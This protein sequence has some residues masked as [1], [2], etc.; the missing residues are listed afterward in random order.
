MI[1][2]GVRL[3]DQI[4]IALD[5]GKLVVF[6]GAGV[7]LP[8]PSNLPLFNGLA[9]QICG[10]PSVPPGKEDQV[11][12]KMARNG[13]DVHVA[14]A[15]ILCHPKTHPTELHR[16][17]LRIFGSPDKVRIVTTNFDSHFSAAAVS[18][19][20]KR[21]VKEFYA[22]ALPLGDDFNG[23]VYLH[24]SAR[25]N[26]KA[27]VLTDKNFGAAYLTRG[28]ARDFLISLFSQY[29][30]LFVGY[31]HNDITTTYL[32]L[33]LNRAQVKPRWALVSSDLKPEAEERWAHLEIGVQQYPTDLS[34]KSNSHYALTD[35]FLGWAKHNRESLL[36]RSRR[37]KGIASSL[38]PESDTVSEYLA[39]CLRHPQLAQDFCNAIR[40]PA[41]IG[42]MNAKRYF[43][44]FFTQ[45]NEELQPHQ[46][47][48]A[49][50]LSTFVR[51]RH[52][53][54]LLELIRENDQR[55]SKS[56]SQ[57]FGHIVWAE[58]TK[59]PDPNFS[60][61]VSVLL[62][63]GEQALSQDMWA[64]LLQT[65]RIPKDT[66]VALRLF[67]LLTTPQIHL[68]TYIDFT[69][70]IAGS[71]ENKPSRMSKKKV[72]Y[73]IEWPEGSRHWL[74]EAWEK[75][76]K[77]N[78]ALL[79][80]PL[81]L[82]ATKQITLAHILLRG[83]GKAGE[84]VDFLSWH[85]SSIAE[86]GQNR[87]ALHECLSVLVDLLRDVLLYWHQTDPARARTQVEAWWAS[88]LPLLQ[89]LAVFGL[90]VDPKLNGDECLEW[91]LANDLVFRL[92]MKKEVFD[93]LA[94]AYPSS[95]ESTRKKLVK[96]IQQ[97][98][99][100]KLR[101]RLGPDTGAYEQFNILTWLQRSDAKCSL[102][103]G[104]I[105]EIKKAYPN[106]EE[107]EH[108][109]FDHWS[110]EVRT[111]DP[112]EG[113]DVEKILSQPPS[114]FV[115]SLLLATESSFR[116]DCWDHLSLL[117]TLFG[118]NRAWGKEFTEELS[119]RDGA[120][121]E[122]WN[123]VFSAWKQVAKAKEDWVWIL[124]VVDGLPELPEIF[125]G[126]ANLISDIWRAEAEIKS[127]DA[128]VGRAAVLMGRAWEICSKVDEPPDDSYREWLT[129]AINH[130]GGWIGEFWVHYCSHLR[131]RAGKEWKGIPLDLKFRMK[132]AIHGAS[133]IK[134]YARIAITPW[135]SYI[136]VWDKK[137]A[138]EHFLPLLDWQRNS[139]VAQQT[140]SVLLNYRRAAF[141]EMEAQLL[142]YY[143]QVC[144][145]VAA[146]LKQTPE[147]AD[148]F[149][150]HTLQNLGHYLAGLAMR[151]IKNPLESGFFRDFLPRL[152]EKVCGSLAQG[153]G[154]F[155][156][157]AP[158][159]VGGVWNDWLEEY[160]DSRL[161]GVP[162]ALSDQETTAMA[163]WG[164][165][166]APIFPK[167][168]E[169]ITQMRLKGIFSYGI[170]DNLAN[171]TLLEQFPKDS[172]RYVNALMKGEDHPHLHKQLVE[173]H[174][175]FRLSIPSELE[176]KEFE[177]LLYLRGWK[178]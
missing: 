124:G 102:V 60:T 21:V 151:V 39:Y 171:S 19:F 157:A 7:S 9:C 51:R 33:G 173:M 28:W 123:G 49:H 146:M 34:N 48:V 139:V 110:G 154:D 134:V 47:V 26:P 116:R 95:S 153:M 158:D 46:R 71:G 165:Y 35:F 72:D 31:S 131:Q 115:D 100:G 59:S 54:L 41:W 141:L 140:W 17:A 170:F 159:K 178:K 125:A 58:E 38:P 111:V 121:K 169:R 29:T 161:I 62:S 137:F 160:L 167:I 168:V 5:E 25:E 74:H 93:V 101:R 86:H 13:T 87:H 83:A 145:R 144:D 97:G 69:G 6:A 105:A 22:P 36:H 126:L 82:L 162:I 75:V 84:Y 50:W 61:W 150:E 118:K 27:M 18:V 135:M 23:I 107:R 64:Y 114:Q 79:A 130:E 32:A 37:M 1:F 55:L 99:R 109:D 77:P 148:Q 80:D 14:A 70:M 8:P 66:G 30:V 176:F 88:K 44:A 132:E 4:R 56:F 149:D 142:P 133:R 94:A 122:I 15:R 92:G 63:Q 96:R 117:Q 91:L 175:K 11:L 138:T 40:H 143:R 164:L 172:C 10:H 155:L 127:D 120:T 108:P 42:W 129:S 90:S 174:A 113:L 85:R 65:C 98:F 163:E 166:S 136:F 68:R 78:L 12:G 52:P 76:L 119:K 53:E 152:P 177:E 89:R 57:L 3:P 106:F 112:A 20:K 24:G 128:I 45:A 73:E 103:A 2:A 67:E 81:A 156:K 43:K 147:K 104:A 16:Q